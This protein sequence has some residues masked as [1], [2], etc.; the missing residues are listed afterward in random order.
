MLFRSDMPMAANTK[1]LFTAYYLFDEIIDKANVINKFIIQS[2]KKAYE[3]VKHHVL[4]NCNLLEGT[5]QYRKAE[6]GKIVFDKI[7][8][9]LQNDIELY[10]N[11]L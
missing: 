3:Y 7:C 10:S 5:S 11:N 9:Q 1:M 6:L 2:E 8:K 4:E